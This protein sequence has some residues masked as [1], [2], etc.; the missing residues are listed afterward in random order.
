MCRRHSTLR[1]AQSTV[2]C[3]SF[4]K[5]SAWYLTAY[6]ATLAPTPGASL[7]PAGPFSPL[8]AWNISRSTSTLPESKP[9]FTVYRLSYSQRRSHTTVPP[10]QVR[11]VQGLVPFVTDHSGELPRGQAQNEEKADAMGLELS[12]HV[13]V[14]AWFPL[15]D[16]CNNGMA[17]TPT[18]QRD[19]PASHVRST[20]TWLVTAKQINT[21]NPTAVSLRERARSRLTRSGRGRVDAR[22]VSPTR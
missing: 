2:L 8:L 16:S 1:A 15:L 12:P 13:A 17:P 10:A 11:H 6:S 3:L 7:P 19:G 20:R 21:A 4:R 14:I 9:S 22:P 5:G 18:S